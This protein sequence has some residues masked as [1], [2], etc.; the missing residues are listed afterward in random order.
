[1]NGTFHYTSLKQ[2]LQAV[3]DALNKE[4]KSWIEEGADLLKRESPLA[5]AAQNMYKNMP[6]KLQKGPCSSSTLDF[7]LVE[8]NPF[9]WR[10]ILFGQPMT[11]LDEGIFK[12]RIVWSTRFPE[13]QPRVTVETPIFHD[14]VSPDGV[15]A[16]IP[17]NPGDHKSHIEAI[18]EALVVTTP[19]PDCFMSPHPEASTLM[20]GTPEQR[21]LYARKL[22]RSAQ[23]SSE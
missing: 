1:M 8:S 12:I 14:K 10:V 6:Q 20:W 5:L 3:R 11:N 13:E 17:T 22:R 16:Y 18:V 15:L 23:Q 19:C 7:E 2:R 9:V 4:T 21:K